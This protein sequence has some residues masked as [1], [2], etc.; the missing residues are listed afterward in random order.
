LKEEEAKEI[1]VRLLNEW[2]RQEE[3]EE[4]DTKMKREREREEK[5]VMSF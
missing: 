1:V 4:E 2:R 5:K 3:W